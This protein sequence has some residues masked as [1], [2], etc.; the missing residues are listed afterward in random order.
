MVDGETLVLQVGV[1]EGR[2]GRLAVAD[3]LP[4]HVRAK[5]AHDQRKVLWRAQQIRNEHVDVDEMG[6]IGEAEPGLQ[7]IQVGGGQAVGAAVTLRQRQQ[8]GRLDGTFQVDVQFRLGH[9]LDEG[10]GFRGDGRRQW[11]VV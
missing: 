4:R 7:G 5:V 3:M 2:K 8:R 11:W 6:E 1:G 9:R 10:G